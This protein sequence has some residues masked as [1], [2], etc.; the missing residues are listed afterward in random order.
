MTPSRTPSGRSDELSATVSR[1]PATRTSSGA[2][3]RGQLASARSSTAETLPVQVVL[4]HGPGGVGKTTLLYEFAYACREIR[5]ARSAASTPAPSTPHPRRSRKALGTAPKPGAE[6]DA[7]R[8]LLVDTLEVDRRAGGLAPRR[9]PADARRRTCSSY[10]PVASPPAG[11]WRTDRGLG[12][13]RG[14]DARSE[15]SAPRES[16]AISSATRASRTRST[17]P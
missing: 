1:P 12:R 17:T 6:T 8:V 16:R 13:P 7:R 3:S 10:S 11:P 9:P 5:R 15:T 4:V 14:V 2:P